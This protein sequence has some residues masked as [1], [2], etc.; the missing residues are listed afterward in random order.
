M[1]LMKPFPP[2]QPEM[3]KVNKTLP[4]VRIC[5]IGKIYSTQPQAK[6]FQDIINILRTHISDEKFNNVFMSLEQEYDSITFLEVPSNPNY[7][8]ELAQAKFDYDTEMY[9]YANVLMPKYKEELAEYKVYEKTVEAGKKKKYFESLED[10]V[11]RLR[12]RLEAKE[13]ELAE[14]KNK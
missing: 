14:S 11:T 7:E 13:K 10:E 3:R 8:K 12:A 4:E 6:S 5:N 1:S 2:K 9:Y